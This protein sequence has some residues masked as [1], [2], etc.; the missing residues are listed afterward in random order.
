MPNHYLE[1]LHFRWSF[2][3]FFFFFGGGG[4]DLSKSEFF[5]EIKPPLELFKSHKRTCVW[6]ALRH[7]CSSNHCDLRFMQMWFPIGMFSQPICVFK[8]LFGKL[9]FIFQKFF[10]YLKLCFRLVF[11]S[12]DKQKAKQKIWSRSI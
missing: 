1:H 3:H 5:S 11:V 10:V 12:E 8:V 4:G 9:S 6:L 7:V 2:W